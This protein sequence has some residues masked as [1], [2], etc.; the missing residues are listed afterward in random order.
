MAGENEKVEGLR[1][2]PRVAYAGDVYVLDE[3]GDGFVLEATDLSRGGV[4]L[5]TALVP[6]EGERYF[7]RFEVSPGEPVMATGVIRRAQRSAEADRPAGF[8]IEFEEL[9]GSSKAILERAT[10]PARVHAAAS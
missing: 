2:Y 4:Y 10:R 6:S 5:K 1:R 8:A 9:A 7:V 3:E